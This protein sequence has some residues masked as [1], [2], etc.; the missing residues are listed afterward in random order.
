MVF[1]FHVL[2]GFIAILNLAQDHNNS[3][4]IY[5][6]FGQSFQELMNN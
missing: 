3:T 1:P 2:F 6:Q 4:F 5:A